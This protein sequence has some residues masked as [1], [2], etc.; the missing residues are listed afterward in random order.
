MET[1]SYQTCAFGALR[2]DS[3]NIIGLAIWSK[4]RLRRGMKLEISELMIP[5]LSADRIWPKL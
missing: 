5:L 1:S 4:C 3:S 2:N